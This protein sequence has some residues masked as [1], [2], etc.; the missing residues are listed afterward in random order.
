MYQQCESKDT[1]SEIY[2]LFNCSLYKKHFIKKQRQIL[3]HNYD[4]LA[5]SDTFIRNLFETSNNPS[6]QCTANFINQCFFVTNRLTSNYR[7]Y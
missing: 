5:N 3:K 2:M 6:I 4:P 7:L 1:E